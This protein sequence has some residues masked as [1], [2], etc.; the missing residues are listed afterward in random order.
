M[1]S[2]Q[3]LSPLVNFLVPIFLYMKPDPFC[4]HRNESR[5]KKNCPLDDALM[6]RTTAHLNGSRG[7]GG[8]DKKN[9]RT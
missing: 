2:L 7:F 4:S 8:G 6:A 9:S 5:S 3:P 1:E